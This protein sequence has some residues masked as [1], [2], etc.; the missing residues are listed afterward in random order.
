M[1]G[2]EQFAMGN[3]K[4]KK[5]PE[6]KIFAENLKQARHGTTAVVEKEMPNGRLPF[7][8]LN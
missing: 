8:I 1:I 4:A 2:S 5:I 7:N 3:L 6:K